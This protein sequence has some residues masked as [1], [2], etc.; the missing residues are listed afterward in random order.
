MDSLA[1]EKEARV[2]IERSHSSLTEDLT[3][4]QEE[5]HSANQRVMTEL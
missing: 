3:K 4:A 2:N 1:R 5:L